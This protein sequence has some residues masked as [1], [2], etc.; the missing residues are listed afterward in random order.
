[1]EEVA[2]TSIFGLYIPKKVTAFPSFLYKLFSKKKIFLNRS[3]TN[4]GLETCQLSAHVTRQQ[5]LTPKFN[6]SKELAV[7]I[8]NKRDGTFW[9]WENKVEGCADPSHCYHI[10]T[11]GNLSLKLHTEASFS[12]SNGNFLKE[13]ELTAKFDPVIKEHLICVEEGTSSHHI[14]NELIG[15]NNFNDR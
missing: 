7:R 10:V 8:K 5:P 14:Q 3:V 11:F 9:G 15:I 6:E 4:L 12:P 13:V 2:T 1:M